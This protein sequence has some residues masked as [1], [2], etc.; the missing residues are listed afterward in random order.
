VRS[1]S[2]ADTN[3]H[4]SSSLNSSFEEILLMAEPTSPSPPVT[5]IRFIA[6]SPPAI[7]HGNKPT[8]KLTQTG[9]ITSAGTE[10]NS[11]IKEMQLLYIH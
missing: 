1:A 9:A 5:S 8:E 10:R 6:A 3:I 7:T 11:Y 2:Q 4:S